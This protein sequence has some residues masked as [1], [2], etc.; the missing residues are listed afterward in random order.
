[1]NDKALATRDA[2][3]TPMEAAAREVRIVPGLDR[4]DHFSMRK[5]G[6]IH[7]GVKV[8]TN[9]GKEYPKATDYFVLPEMLARDEDFRDKLASMGEDPEKPTRLPIMLM[10]DNLGVN[11][12]S[13]FDCYGAGGKLKCRSYDG[14]TCT[15]LNEQT[16]QYEDLPCEFTDCKLFSKGECARYHRLR[17]LLPDAAELGYWQIATKSDNNRGAL[18]REIVDLRKFLRGH[19]AGADLILT[20]TNERTF[21]VPVNGKLLATNPFLLHLSLGRSLRKLMAE[22]QTFAE[23][24]AETIEESYDYEERVV[25]EGD[26][27]VG[28]PEPVDTQPI[29]AEPVDDGPDAEL[30][31][32]RERIADMTGGNIDVL[33]DLSKRLWG[34]V[35]P[36][37]SW[38]VDQCRQAIEALEGTGANTS[39]PEDASLFATERG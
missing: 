38:T 32:L 5:L 24:D 22:A 39:S 29:E 9:S 25:D 20:L 12:L 30:A 19:V 21:H 14:H 26:F 4:E 2:A 34:K 27:D 13:S 33:R 3:I 23:V 17:F 35:I 8:R 7:L 37:S 11:I 10:S 16:L 28:E 36:A 6:N 1:M 31:A 15:R 18:V